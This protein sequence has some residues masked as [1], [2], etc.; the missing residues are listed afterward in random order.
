MDT[1]ADRLKEARAEASL[2]QQQLADLCRVSQS[3]IDEPPQG[4]FFLPLVSATVLDI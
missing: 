2:T 1:L 4:G 3:T